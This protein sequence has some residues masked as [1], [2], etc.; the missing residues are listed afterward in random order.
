MQRKPHSPEFKEQ[1]LAKARDRG[2]RKLKAAA[3]EVNIRLATL[4]G[5]LKSVRLAGAC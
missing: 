2:T 5:W 4:K 3:Q 1:A